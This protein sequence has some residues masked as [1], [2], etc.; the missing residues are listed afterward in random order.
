[1]AGEL[2]NLL[3]QFAERNSLAKP[4]ADASGRYFLLLDGDLEVAV[5]QGG[6]CI[7]LEG[8]LE[9]LPADARKAE[10]L[11]SHRL[12]LHLARLR[13]KHE[14]L[15]LEADSED[16]VLFRQL[17]VRYLSINDFEQ[18]LEDFANSLEFWI[19]RGSESAPLQAPPPTM[20]MLFP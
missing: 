1:M 19:S 4:Q 10:A 16:F 18:A 2:D 9:P 5:L 7:Y 12:R 13:D 17:S 6:D 15:S 20:Q 3:T 8:R 14:V 11:L